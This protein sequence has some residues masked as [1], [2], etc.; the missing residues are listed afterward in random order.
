MLAVDLISP[1]LSIFHFHFS[2]FHFFVFTFTFLF[3]FSLFEVVHCLLIVSS[4]RHFPLSFLRR[5]WEGCRYLVTEPEISNLLGRS[6][7]LPHPHTPKRNFSLQTFYQSQATPQTTPTNT[8]SKKF[9]LLK[10]LRKLS[11]H[12]LPLKPAETNKKDQFLSNI[13]TLKSQN[14]ISSMYEDYWVGC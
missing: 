6:P 14:C 12:K 4:W 3:P 1:S 11:N 7:K 13:F 2:H 9:S 10:P 8:H 5:Q